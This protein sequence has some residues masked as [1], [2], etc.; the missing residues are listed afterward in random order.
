MKITELRLAKLFSTKENVTSTCNKNPT[1]AKK[2]EGTFDFFSISSI[3][4][5][6][7]PHYAFMQFRA[8]LVSQ[9]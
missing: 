1:L 6:S 7:V 5:I 8:L 9:Y 3:I 2:V 4:V